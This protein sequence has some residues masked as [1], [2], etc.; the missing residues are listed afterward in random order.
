MVED[1]TTVANYI[2]DPEVGPLILQVRERGWRR[3]RERVGESG[4]EGA[5]RRRGEKGRKERG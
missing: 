1:P 5:E 2:N 3:G 4:R